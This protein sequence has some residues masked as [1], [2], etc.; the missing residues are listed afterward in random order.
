MT[1]GVKMCH[2]LITDGITKKAKCNPDTYVFFAL[3]S[4]ISKQTYAGNQRW[5]YPKGVAAKQ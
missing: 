4:W 5:K 1:D 3:A 2:S